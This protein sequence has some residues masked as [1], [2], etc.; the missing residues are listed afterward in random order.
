[1]EMISLIL[2]GL[3]LLAAGVCLVM[4]RRE[5]KRSVK[6]NAALVRF[7]EK[8]AKAVSTA[9]GIYSDEHIKKCIER[10]EKLEQGITPDYEAAKQAAN[11]VN[12]F[13]KGITNIL[14]FDPMEALKAER[15]KG[16]GEPD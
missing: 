6:R 16:M 14:G 2:S 10:I 1:M 8:E 4:I 12:D 9:A 5:K 7:V 15:Q 11:A 3:A 13:S